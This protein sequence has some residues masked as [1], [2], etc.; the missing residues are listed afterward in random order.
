MPRVCIVV[1]NWNGIG[2]TLECLESIHRLEYPDF[3]VIVVDNGSRDGSAAILRR[4][5][6]QIALIENRRNLG[7]SAGNNQGMRRAWEDGA[8]YVWLLNNDTVV[9]PDSLG[10]L[11]EEAERSPE[12]GLIS[13]VVHHYEDRERVQ[14][15]GS[16]FDYATHELVSVR[17]WSELDDEWVQRHLVLWGTALLIRKSVVDA[18]GYLS[19]EYFA[20]HEDCDYSLRALRSNFRTAVRRDSRVFHKDSRS[21]G[22]WSPMQVFLRTRNDY[23]LWRDNEPRSRRIAMIGQF[24]ARTIPVATLLAD[25]GNAEGVEA[26]MRG[27]WAALRGVGGAYEPTAAVPAWFRRLFGVFVG[28]HP[29]FWVALFR[30]DVKRLARRGASPGPETAAGGRPGHR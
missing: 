28:W 25:K 17:R 21:T 5:Y 20:Y 9:E 11:V 7:Y 27:V 29:Y 30:G 3:G 23:F 18:I 26:C 13:P 14:F 19:E 4:A 2:D 1:L 24:M 16:Y 15:M 10:K 12:T 6:P 22:K 8:D